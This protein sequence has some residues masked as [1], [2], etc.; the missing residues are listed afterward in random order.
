MKH[1]L[2]T[3]LLTVFCFLFPCGNAFAWVYTSDYNP[4]NPIE[5][6]IGE[7]SPLVYVIYWILIALFAFLIIRFIIKQIMKHKK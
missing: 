1:K 2:I 6:D 4:G 7:P 3:F 5:Y